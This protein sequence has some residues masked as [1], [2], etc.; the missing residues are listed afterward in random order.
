MYMKE[1]E[2]ISLVQLISIT[3]Q[4]KADM[5]K[6]TLGEEGINCVFQKRAVSS[7]H[8]FTVDGMAE[9]KIL[10]DKKDLEAAKELLKNLWFLKG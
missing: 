6:N 1:K 10:V 7:V 9:T 3:D 8:P 2:N 5:I 4:V